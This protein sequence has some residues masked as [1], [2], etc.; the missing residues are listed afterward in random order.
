MGVS[1]TRTSS[2]LSAESCPRDVP[3][4]FLGGREFCRRSFWRPAISEEI[5]KLMYE[6]NLLLD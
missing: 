6:H 2:V 4:S 3:K 1:R 5:R